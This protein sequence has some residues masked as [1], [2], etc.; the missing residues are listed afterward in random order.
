MLYVYK[1]NFNFPSMNICIQ[2]LKS[3]KLCYKKTTPKETHKKHKNMFNFNIKTLKIL[4]YICKIL[5][6]YIFFKKINRNLNVSFVFFFPH[7]YM[8][9]RSNLNLLNLQTCVF[10]CICSSSLNKKRSNCV[11]FY[12]MFSIK[13]QKFTV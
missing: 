7:I 6:L 2:M 8:H 4:L 5:F 13:Q 10:V 1:K 9:M 3:R 11:T 12:E